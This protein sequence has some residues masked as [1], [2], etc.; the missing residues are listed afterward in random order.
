MWKKEMNAVDRGT[1]HRTLLL[2]PL[3]D[4]LIKEDGGGSDQIQ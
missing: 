2:P 1:M 4:C 3:P